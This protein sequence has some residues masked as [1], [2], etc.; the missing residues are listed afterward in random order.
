M[1]LHTRVGAELVEALEAAVVAVLLHVLLPLQVVSAVVAVELLSHG[2][3]FIA[4]RTCEG[5]T[6]G[7]KS[8]GLG[9]RVCLRGSREA[10]PGPRQQAPHQDTRDKSILPWVPGTLKGGCGWW[11]RA[12]LGWAGWRG[13]AGLHQRTCCSGSSLQVAARGLPLHRKEVP[14]SSL[15]TQPGAPSP[16]PTFSAQRVSSGGPALLA[17]KLSSSEQKLT[18]DSGPR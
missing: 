7:T 15:E 5:W 6:G 3:Y 14:R 4:G 2:A 9:W 12:G 13:D 10:T 8:Q 11:A 1:A 16:S 17:T 18:A